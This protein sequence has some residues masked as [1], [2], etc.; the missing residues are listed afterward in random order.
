MSFRNAALPTLA[1]ALAA[2][3]AVAQA[4][5][6]MATA[7]AVEHD[8]SVLGFA[9]VSQGQDFEGSFGTWDATINFDP[10]NLAASMAEVTIDM[11]SAS[12]DDPSRD[13]SLPEDDWF[14]IA[15]FP[16]ATFESSSIEATG[17]NSYVAHG[18]LTIRD[19]SKAVDLPF[20]VDIDG[21]NAAM[22]G[23]LTIDRTDF[24]VGQGAWSSGST[25]ATSVTVNVAITATKIG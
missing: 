10:A 18:T 1:L 19:M 17:D 6:M 20:T 22:A 23:S 15:M 12:T 24:G 3:P 16:E 7:W 14:A 25:V 11:G 13:S 5:E 4:P 21:D 2:I 9:G 8:A